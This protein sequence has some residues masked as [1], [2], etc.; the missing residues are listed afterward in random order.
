MAVDFFF[1]INLLE[2]MG[3]GQDQTHD[4]WICSQTHYLLRYAVSKEYQQR[5]QAVKN[6]PT[7]SEDSVT[8]SD[9]YSF[10]RIVSLHIRSRSP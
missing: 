7:G 3:P 6:P 9:F 5:T 4:P 8:K 10:Y 2:S 1:M